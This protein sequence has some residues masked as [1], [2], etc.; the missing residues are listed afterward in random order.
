MSEEK[1][2]QCKVVRTNIRMNGKRILEGSVISVTA[3]K[4]KELG[5]LLQPVEAAKAPTAPAGD[6]TPPA[7]AAGAPDTNINN[8]PAKAPTAPAGTKKP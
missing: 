4:L 6:Q 8:T 5:S 1:L 2:I 7:P 3:E